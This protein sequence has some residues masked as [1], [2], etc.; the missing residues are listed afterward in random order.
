MKAGRAAALMLL[1][2]RSSLVV[3]FLHMAWRPTA[4]INRE[5]IRYSGWRDTAAQLSERDM[6]PQ[7]R[8]KA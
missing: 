8:R 2:R 3:P 5:T 6:L 1:A 7:L 4:W